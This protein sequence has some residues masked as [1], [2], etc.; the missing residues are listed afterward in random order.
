MVDIASHNTDGTAHADIRGEIVSA[1]NAVMQVLDGTN[2]YMVVSNKVLTVYAE[3]NS[4][5]V[6]IWSSTESSGGIDQ[7][8]IN[9]IYKAIYDVELLVADKAPKA[10]G[11]Y[12]PDGSANPDPSYMVL[13]NRPLTMHTSG[14]Q[15]STYG[16]IAVLTGSGEVAYET[17]GDGSIRWGLDIHTNFIQMVRGDSVTIGANAT[18]CKL[19]AGELQIVY[20]YVGDAFPILQHTP[21]LLMPFDLYEGATWEDNEDGTATAYVPATGLSGFFKATTTYQVGAYVDIGPVVRFRDGIQGSVQQPPVVYDSTITIN[22][23]G[24]NYRIPAERVQ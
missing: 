2:S 7:G 15:W 11:D 9:A 5:P 12:A 1:T 22:V 23:G 16:E 17:G 19:V 13:L 3:S 20:P 4:V 10:W 21:D 8:V 14:F 6:Q 24:T 18:K